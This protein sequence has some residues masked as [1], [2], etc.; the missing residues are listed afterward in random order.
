[1]MTATP[2]RVA[3]DEEETAVSGKGITNQNPL[4]RANKPRQARVVNRSMRINKPK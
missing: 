2:S 3:V 4:F 1:M